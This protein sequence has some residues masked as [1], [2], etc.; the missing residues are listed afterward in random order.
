ME[1]YRT[2]A[3]FSAICLIEEF[4]MTLLARIEEGL[5]RRA[6]NAPALGSLDDSSDDLI[7]WHSHMR[8]VKFY[9]MC[10]LKCSEYL[11]HV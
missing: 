7:L 10:I 2:K 8:F 1:K 4:V 6:T 3:I 11:L 5:P 9:C